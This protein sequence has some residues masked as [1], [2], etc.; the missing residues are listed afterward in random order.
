MAVELW[1]EAE[2]SHPVVD[3][4]GFSLTAEVVFPHANPDGVGV[5]PI[6]GGQSVLALR[7]KR[8]CD[9]STIKY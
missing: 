9:A 7:M 1:V 8:E 6:T 2:A 5:V 3:V 4:P